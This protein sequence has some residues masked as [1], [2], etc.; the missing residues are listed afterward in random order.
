[1][2]FMKRRVSTPKDFDEIL[3]VTLGPGVSVPGSGRMLVTATRQQ[4]VTALQTFGEDAVA[5]QVT[6]LSDARMRKLYQRA[7]EIF[8]DQ[9]NYVR[10]LCLAA[11]E[12]IEGLSRPLVRT[13]RKNAT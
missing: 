13:R 3:G 1:M 2:A 4:L 8:A 9:S 6:S 10:A 5:G 12:V 11:V 7:G